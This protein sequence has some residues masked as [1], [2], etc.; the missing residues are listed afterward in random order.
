[1]RLGMPRDEQW[2]KVIDNL[3]P[4]TV[5]NGIYPALEFPVENNAATMTT[6]LYGILP[7]KDIDKEAMRNTLH[8]VTRNTGRSSEHYLG[9]GDASHVCGPS[10]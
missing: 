2:D 9:H 7:G 5:R 1:M 4:L 8:A 6:F 10:E 3:A